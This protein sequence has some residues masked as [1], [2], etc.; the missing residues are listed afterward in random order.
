MNPGR[1]QL[2]IGEIEGFVF[3]VF[4]QVGLHL[5]RPIRAIS[6]FAFGLRST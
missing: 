4:W 3:I 5:Y 1:I 2:P 6:I